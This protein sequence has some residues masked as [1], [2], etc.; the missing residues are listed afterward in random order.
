MM[1]VTI[2]RLLTSC[3]RHRCIFDPDLDTV[4]DSLSPTQ[5]D[6]IV[7]GDKVQLAAKTSAE[8][9]QYTSIIV[10]IDSMQGDLF[11]GVVEKVV[12]GNFAGA[13]IVEDVEF[14]RPDIVDLKFVS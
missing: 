5:R 8:D 3:L 9:A 6:A 14:N 4:E 13:V 2:R 1:R 12:G 10:C 11:T 7:P